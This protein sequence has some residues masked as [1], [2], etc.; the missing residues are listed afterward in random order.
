[1]PAIF[2]VVSARQILGHA[3]DEGAQVEAAGGIA[4]VDAG[5]RG[6]GIVAMLF[7]VVVRGDPGGQHDAEHAATARTR[8]REAKPHD[9]RILGSAR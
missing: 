1:M 2:A 5:G 7:G 4:E 8:E 9:V 6:E 3:V